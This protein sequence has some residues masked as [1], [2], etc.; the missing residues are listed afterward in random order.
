MVYHSEDFLPEKRKEAFLQALIQAVSTLCL[1]PLFPWSQPNEMEKKRR[2]ALACI[3]H[4]FSF[5][6]GQKSGVAPTTAG[7]KVEEHAAFFFPDPP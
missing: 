2:N 6:I 5:L 7:K 4:T 3:T 1:V